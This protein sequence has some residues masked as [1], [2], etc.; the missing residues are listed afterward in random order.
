MEKL[1]TVILAGGLGTR[2]RDVVP[3]LPKVLAPVNDKPFLDIIL[4]FLNN[5]DYIENVIIA[6]GYMAEKII[7]MYSDSSKYKFKIKFSVEKKLL[8]T[9]GAIKNVL[10]Q[11]ETN[12]VLVL[13]GDSY[14]DTDLC[15]FFEEH[16]NKKASMSIVLKKVGNASRYGCVRFDKN[17]RI[18]DFEEKKNLPLKGYINTGMY[19]IKKEIF[20]KVENDKVISL[21]KELLPEFMKNGVY[22]YISCG[23]FIDIGIPETY[24][25]ADNYLKEVC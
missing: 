2:L 23:K 16:I 19:L 21:E 11:T 18:L 14:I 8:D 3:E 1:D 4:S 10:H 17:H 22:G 13:N 5:Y 7:S 25:K 24:K 20:D 12:N 15:V 6:A 9:G